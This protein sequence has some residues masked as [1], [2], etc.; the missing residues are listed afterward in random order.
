MNEQY[1]LATVCYYVRIIECLDMFV[2]V[3]TTKNHWTNHF[4]SQIQRKFVQF[5]IR[6]KV[7]RLFVIK[8]CTEISK[9]SIYSN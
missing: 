2:N 8:P 1:H 3:E 5:D 6:E 9:G 7:R 4:G